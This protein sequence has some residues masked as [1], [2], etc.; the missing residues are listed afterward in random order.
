MNRYA[1]YFAPA[2]G[3]PWWDFGAGWL[4]RDELR[5][6]PLA[7]PAVPGFDAGQLAQLTGEPRRYGFH[8]TLK[9]PFRLREGA[10][11]TQLRDRLRLLAGRL[12]RLPLGG[13][14]PR[15]MEGFVALVPARAPPG[16]DA[17]AAQCVTDLDGLRAPLTEAEIARRQPRR[18]DARGRELLA[19]HGYPHVLERFRF[20]MTLS[21][22]VD[23]ATA[24]RLMVHLP[25]A[26]DRL[27]TGHPL[28][29]DRLCL[30][31]EP[32]PGAAFVRLHEEE[33]A[34]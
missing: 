10:T 15:H 6:A 16:L 21:G 33:L 7:Q 29:L 5:D 34:P 32:R 18:L 17:L 25:P 14:V 11:E 8:A 31:G 24:A 19:A 22:L 30:F 4:G 23:A 12:R 3:S 20:H 1:V 9:A 26:L 27:D 2:V 28:L 13:L